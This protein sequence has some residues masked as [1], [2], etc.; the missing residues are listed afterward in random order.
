MRRETESKEVS[1]EAEEPDQSNNSPGRKN[2]HMNQ[3]IDFMD[4]RRR[5]CRW[6]KRLT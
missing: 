3:S 2:D 1:P 4:D 6:L 5:F